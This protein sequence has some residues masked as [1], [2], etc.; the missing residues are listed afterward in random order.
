[1]YMVCKNFNGPLLDVR[2]HHLCHTLKDP[3]LVLG[4]SGRGLSER[5][6]RVKARGGGQLYRMCF[7]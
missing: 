4:G 1:M 7:A 5:G 2:L 6:R 3:P